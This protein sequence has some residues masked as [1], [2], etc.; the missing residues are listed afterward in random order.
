M[1]KRVAVIGIIIKN[2]REHA[3]RVNEIL[4]DFGYLIVGRLGVPYEEKDMSIISIIV[5][6]TNDEIGALSGKLG[7]IDGVKA[8]AVIAS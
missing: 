2:R 4:T 6:A 8:K 7:S 3:A 1:E 5:D